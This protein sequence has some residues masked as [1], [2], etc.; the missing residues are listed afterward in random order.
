MLK[1]TTKLHGD[2][3]LGKRLKKSQLQGKLTQQPSHTLVQPMV[4]M[5]GLKKETSANFPKEYV[6]YTSE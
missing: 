5:V 3:C 2:V 6:H 1:R 4:Q